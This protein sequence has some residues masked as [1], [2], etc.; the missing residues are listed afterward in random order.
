VSPLRHVARV[1][2]REQTAAHE[3]AQKSPAHRGLHRGDGLRIEPGGRVEDDERT[4]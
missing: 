4:G 3:A 1:I 2:A